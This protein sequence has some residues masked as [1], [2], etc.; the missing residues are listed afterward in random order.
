MNLKESIVFALRQL[1]GNKGRTLLTMLGMFIGIGSV[2][3]ILGL[4]EG[5]KGQMASF[6]EEIGIGAFY[7]YTK[8]GET[9]NLITEEDIELLN[10]MP[11]I[12]TVMGSINASG[13]AYDSKREEMTFRIYGSDP[14]YAEVIDK[15]ELLAGRFINPDDDR[16]Y[17]R[18]IVV[19]DFFSKVMFNKKDY[20]SIVGES[21]AL[22][23]NNQEE[24][25]TIIGVYKTNVKLTDSKE[26]LKKRLQSQ[27]MYVPI[28]TLALICEYGEGYSFVDGL[29]NTEYDA[30][31]VGAKVRNFLNKRHQ[32]KDEY[33]VMTLAQ[34]MDMINQ[35][36][37]MITLF[38]GTVAGI[39]LLVGGVGIMNIMLVTVK[40]RTREIGIRKALGATNGVI[41]RQFLIEALMITIIAGIIGMLMGYI[42]AMLI[43]AQF[44]IAAK[45]SIGM[46]LFSAGVSIFIG[47][48]F[49]V[50]PAYQAA[51]L[52]PIEALRYE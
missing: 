37:N 1:I 13:I 31:E 22:T 28:K 26:M 3:M 48:V 46:I 52:E 32:Q 2:I 24:Q 27:K 35:M 49:G 11:E 8:T 21:I 6:G 4:G 10:S 29:A 39:S 45:L 40:E 16:A 17:A 18:A 12:K 30:K 41:L 34:Q 50:Y 9:H 47:L 15:K 20:K 38:I 44:D 14:N 23:I 5:F 33:E 42:G 19:P 43:G 36:L 7:A 51:Q 25:F